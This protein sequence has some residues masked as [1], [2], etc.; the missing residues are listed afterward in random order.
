[1]QEVAARTLERLLAPMVEIIDQVVLVGGASI[2]LWVDDP[3]APPAR[4]TNDT[5][6]IVA[7][8][9]QVHYHQLSERLRE[10]GFV[11]DADSNIICRWRHDQTGWLYDVMPL[12]Q[13]ILGFSN[14]WYADAYRE[15]AELS[16]PGGLIVRAATPP[17]LVATKL[18]A[19]EDRGGSDYLASHDMYDIVALVDGR[20]TLGVEIGEAPTSLRNWLGSRFRSLRDGGRL[21]DALLNYVPF[22]APPDA[23]SVI[24]RRV[25]AIA[26]GH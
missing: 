1:M 8:R 16:L 20:P 6:V 24:E 26:N 22:D 12:D 10:L 4:P 25:A 14:P 15:A 23:G 2:P 5:D 9:T 19:F 3:A 11:E 21:D 7:A 17:Y 13:D 18:V